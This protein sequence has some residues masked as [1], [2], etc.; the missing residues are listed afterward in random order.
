MTTE[1]MTHT[2][3]KHTRTNT[4]RR[5]LLTAKNQELIPLNV[6]P[7]SLN[8][9][10]YDNV[11]TT[12]NDYDYDSNVVLVVPHGECT[13][14]LKA[15]H[16]QKLGKKDASVE[17]PGNKKIKGNSNSASSSRATKAKS[18]YASVEAPRIKKLMAPMLLLLL[19]HL[20]RQ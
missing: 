13:Y 18:K 4:R 17:A 14:N 2:T 10:L 6:L 5:N 3:R 19:L 20:Q 16:A 8:P 15:Y 9:L 7:P 12:T 11:T 1:E